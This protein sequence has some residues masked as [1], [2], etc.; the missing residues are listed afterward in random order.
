MSGFKRKNNGAE[1]KRRPKEMETA[2]PEESGDE[3]VA[4]EDPFEDEYEEE[5]VAE[6]EDSDDDDEEDDDNEDG[7]EDGDGRAGSRKISGRKAASTAEE[8]VN[9]AP[10]QVWRPGIDKL[11]EGETLEYDPSA[12]I[13]YHQ[14]GSEWPCLSFDILRDTLG[15]ARTR[16]PHTMF[17]AAGSQADRAENNKITLLSL[18]DLHKTY[19]APDD[20]DSDDDDDDDDGLDEDPVL[21]HVCIPHRGCVNR[22]RSCPQQPGLLATMADDG[23][24]HIFDATSVLNGL[25][26]PGAPPGA[27]PKKPA[28]T[29]HKHTQE[30][31]AVD[32]SPRETGRLATGDCAGLIHVWQ[33]GGGASQWSVDPVPYAG[34]RGSVE[35]LQWSP[36]EATVFI[37]SSTDRTFKVWDIRAKTAQIGVDA[38]SEDVNV[39]SWSRTQSYLL[40]TGCDDGSFKVWDLR[41]VR[42]SKALA[43]FSFHKGPI[44]SVDWAPHDES[45]LC[46]SSADNQVTIWDLSVE[47][48]DGEVAA[49]AAGGSNGADLS[50][51]PPQ[52]LFIHQ[53]QSNVKEVHH[54][55]HIPGVIVTTAE[56]G[57]NVFKPNINLEQG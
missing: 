14:I 40:A 36:T 24:A 52:L 4:F 30:G 26:T 28:F 53:G 6:D 32:W 44:T 54:H 8:E 55:S 12:Y 50:V 2:S 27:V 16:F 46:V 5:E 56:D 51:Y 49:A 37:S 20:D 17:L 10:K 43:N 1:D 45:V 34:H 13:M 3:E 22:L 42:E 38:H 33:M 41:A 25:M 23:K 48:D 21:D 47:A 18:R 9:I 39:L 11:E 15:D 57:F 35:D 29:F 31:Y 19:Q 7:A